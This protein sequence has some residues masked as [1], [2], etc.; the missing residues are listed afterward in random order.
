VEFQADGQPNGTPAAQGWLG[1]GYYEEE[2]ARI[3]GVWLISYMRLTRQRMD[4]LPVDHPQAK[5]S[6]HS[7]TKGWL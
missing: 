1:W 3:D 6:R 5:F 2:Y 7:P 4:E